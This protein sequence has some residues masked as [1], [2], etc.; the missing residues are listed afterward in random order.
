[1]SGIDLWQRRIGEVGHTG[2]LGSEA[3]DI[4]WEPSAEI[5]SIPISKSQTNSSQ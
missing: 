3:L 4:N 1:M 2:W 5:L